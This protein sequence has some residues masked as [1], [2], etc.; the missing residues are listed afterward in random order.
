VN[1][2]APGHI[3]P[4]ADGTK[5]RVIGISFRRSEGGPE[6]LPEYL[7]GRVEVIASAVDYPTMQVPGDWRN[8]PTTLTLVTWRIE[9]S[10]NGRV[11]VPEHTAWDVRQ[12]LPSNTDLWRIY[13]RG[14]HQNMTVFRPHYSWLHPGAYLFKLQTDSTRQ[15]CAMTSTTSW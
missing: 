1:P 7:Q 6:L 5:P 14:T 2:L 15:R 13:A 9:R 4:Y 8:L 11:A 3:G 12:R 10:E